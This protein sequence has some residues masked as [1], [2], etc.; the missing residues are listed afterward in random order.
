MKKTLIIIILL[1]IAALIYGAVFYCLG[2]ASSI[3]FVDIPFSIHF[4][5]MLLKQSNVLDIIQNK[6]ELITLIKTPIKAI[7]KAFAINRIVLICIVVVITFFLIYKIAIFCIFNEQIFNFLGLNKLIK[8]K[9]GTFGTAKFADTKDIAKMKK[10]ET[11]ENAS[12]VILGS[13]KKPYTL[14][15]FKKYNLKYRITIGPNVKM[16]NGHAIVVSGSGAGKTFSFV[17]TNAINAI[18]DGVNVLF[19]DPKGELFLTLSKYFEQNGYV[20]RAL[21]LIDISKSDRFN[22][23]DLVESELDC[24]IYIDVLFENA[25]SLESTGVN[26]FW[27]SGAKDLLKAIILFVK[28]EYPKE[29]QNMGVVYDLIIESSNIDNMDILLQDIPDDTAIK[30]AYRLFK[31]AD[32][33]ARQGIIQ[34]LGLKLQIFQHEEIRQL[35]SH[36]DMDMYDLKTKKTAFFLLIPDTHNSYNFIPSIFMNF[37]FIKLPHLHDTTSDENIKKTKIR[38]FADEIANVGKIAN[39]KNVITTL[40]SRKIDFYPIYQ[41]IAQIKESF[42]T[43]WETITGNCDT[44]LCLGVNDGETAN[45]ISEKLGKQ[46]IRTI[47]KTRSDGLKDMTNT[48]RWSISEQPRELMQPSEITKIK[49]SKC[50]IFIRGENPMLLYK[51]PFSALEE[52]QEIKKLEISMS[53]YTPVYLRQ[54][55]KENI[56]NK[57]DIGEKQFVIKKIDKQKETKED[58]PKEDKPKEETQKKNEKENDVES[59]IDEIMNDIIDDTEDIL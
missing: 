55:K 26:D 29:K 45:Y 38:I 50:I 9:K 40:R 1:T 8:D 11:L 24:M 43:G 47:S 10:E 6:Q 58:K 18:R 31:D 17:L 42:G 22:P 36:S 25:R 12:G 4:E 59:K 13:T 49:K 33:K 44:F 56:E 7:L 23:L 48:K 30:R 14:E 16:L 20:V 2:I 39:L 15:K 52:Y 54:D 41:N 5:N 37:M 21:N 19:T 32:E 27:D 46:T 34:G 53:D 57:E 3:E 28:S 51:Y 35:T